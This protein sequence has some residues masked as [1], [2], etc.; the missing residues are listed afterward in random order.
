MLCLYLHLAVVVE[1]LAGLPTEVAGGNIIAQER[2][3]TVLIVAE[4]V[5]Q[6]FV[7]CGSVTS[8][9]MNLGCGMW[10]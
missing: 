2:A 7:S 8:S 10:C 4:A 9:M 6:A 5:M 1:A 3:R